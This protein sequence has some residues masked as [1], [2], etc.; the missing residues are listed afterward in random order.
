M[1]RSISA[2]KLLMTKRLT[3]ETRLQPAVNSHALGSCCMNNEHSFGG[4]PVSPASSCGVISVCGGELN[5]FRALIESSI[6]SACHV[7]SNW[8]LTGNKERIGK[9]GFTTFELPTP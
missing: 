5:K 4:L 2:L 7:E 8:N 6:V 1:K 3:H 9:I